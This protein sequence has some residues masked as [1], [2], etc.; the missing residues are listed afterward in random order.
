MVSAALLV[1]AG[2][3]V[4]AQVDAGRED[5]PVVVERRAVAER[6]AARL[7]ID[8]ASRSAWTTA[9]PSFRRAS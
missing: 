2:Q 1:V 5:Q 6:D 7:R 9:M 3:R 4:E 8:R